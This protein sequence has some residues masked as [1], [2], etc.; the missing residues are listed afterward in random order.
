MLRA[1]CDRDGGIEEH[2]LTGHYQD[3]PRN[4]NQHV[5]CGRKEALCAAKI[6]TEE[7]RLR[8]DIPG[9]SEA[10][11]DVPDDARAIGI[12]EESS[13]PDAVHGWL[14]VGTVELYPRTANAA[15]LAAA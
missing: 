8:D 2:E 1:L 12:F 15:A 13:S 6:I 3:A 14:L 4:S 9:L 10:A 5:A 11:M 7:L